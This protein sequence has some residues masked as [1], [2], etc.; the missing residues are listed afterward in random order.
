MTEDDAL[1]QYFALRNE[2]QGLS[3]DPVDSRGRIYGSACGRCNGPVRHWTKDR[4]Y[5]CGH[6]G[7]KWPHED[8]EIWK[9][10]VVTSRRPGSAERRIQRQVDLGVAL[11]NL[12]HKLPVEATLYVAHAVGGISQR[13]IHRTAPV[14]VRRGIPWNRYEI[15]QAIRRAREAWRAELARLG[16]RRA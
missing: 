8:H 4:G 9:G 6:C 5:V 10:E 14:E 7:A 12:R 16:R 1:R 13:E 11:K 2:A 15:G 3:M